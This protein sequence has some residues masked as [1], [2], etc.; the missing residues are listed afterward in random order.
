MR[1]TYR[2]KSYIT[3]E[4]RDVYIYPVYKPAKTR[5]KKAKPSTEVQQK[6]NERHAHEK[7]TRLAHANFTRSDYALGLSY[8]NNPADDKTATKAVKNFL[9]RLARMRKKLGLDA[10]KYICITERST[11]GRYHHHLIINGGINRDLVE[12]LWGLG[13]ANTKR[14]QFADTGIA[15]LTKYM[16]KDFAGGKRWNASKNLIDPQPKTN[17]S[18]VK[19]RKRASDL[20][21][22]N[23]KDMWQQLYPEYQ[24]VDLLPFHHEDTGGVYLFARLRRL[25]GKFIEPRRGSI[26]EL[27]T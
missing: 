20:A 21:K 15:G 23:D 26:H 5:G 14:L 25:D 19:S 22:G 17:D 16:V 8:D 11:K 6:L 9:R 1:T 2:E 24:V 3:G 10:L 13:Y 7:L 27:E 12:N 4:Y 18:R